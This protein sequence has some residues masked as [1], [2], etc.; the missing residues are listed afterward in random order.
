VKVRGL[1]GWVNGRVEAGERQEEVAL[2]DKGY[3]FRSCRCRGESGWEME[4]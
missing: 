4:A 2:L 3:L 1:L